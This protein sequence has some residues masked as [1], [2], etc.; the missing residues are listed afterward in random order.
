MHLAFCPYCTSRCGNAQASAGGRLFL[1]AATSKKLRRCSRTGGTFINISKVTRAVHPLRY[2]RQQ[3]RQGG[4][5]HGSMRGNAGAVRP[6]LRWAAGGLR[7]DTDTGHQQLADEE[8]PQ[9]F[10]AGNIQLRYR[11]LSGYH[12][13]QDRQGGVSVHRG[14]RVLQGVSGKAGTLPLQRRGKDRDHPAEAQGQ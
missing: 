11:R 14:R 1:F 9:V 2:T 7:H 5:T 6:L 3:K 12:A 10:C 13:S 8:H 4:Q